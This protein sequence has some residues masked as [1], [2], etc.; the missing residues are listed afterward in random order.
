MVHAGNRT[1]GLLQ[2]HQHLVVVVADVGLLAPHGVPHLVEGVALHI[3]EHEG[4]CE[5]VAPLQLE[6]HA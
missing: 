2:R 4:V 5:V 3:F 6:A 1:H